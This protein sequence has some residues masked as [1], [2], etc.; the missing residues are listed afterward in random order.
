MYDHKLANL[1]LKRL[2]ASGVALS[3]SSSLLVD[4]MR[5][6]KSKQHPL[7][8]S[9]DQTWADVEEEWL[10]AEKQKNTLRWSDT[11]QKRKDRDLT[12]ILSHYHNWLSTVN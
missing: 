2:S 7:S 9:V 3:S 11:E 8:L 10:R 6:A 1:M 5:F 12:P 4:A